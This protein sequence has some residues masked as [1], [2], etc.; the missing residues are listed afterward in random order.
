MSVKNLLFESIDH[1]DV[2]DL[3]QT[4]V[5]IM[6]INQQNK[7]KRQFILLFVIHRYRGEQFKPC[8]QRY[9]LSLFHTLAAVS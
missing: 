4:I 8:Y 6:M 2:M 1:T 3:K 5:I 7:T 9:N